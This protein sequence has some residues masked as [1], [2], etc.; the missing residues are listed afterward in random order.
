MAAG[1]HFKKGLSPAV[2]PAEHSSAQF[3]T[4]AEPQHAQQH[5]VSSCMG[6]SATAAALSRKLSKTDEIRKCYG[7][8]VSY[9]CRLQKYDSK[10][11]AA[12]PRDKAWRESHLS[13]MLGG[14]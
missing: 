1:L 8:R 2:R 4:H 14:H 7:P 12:R 9:E 3:N 6:E 10:K 11:V 5:V 13:W